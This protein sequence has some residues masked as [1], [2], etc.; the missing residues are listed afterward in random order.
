MERVSLSKV[1]DAILGM[2]VRHIHL[3][4]AAND[5]DRRLSTSNP[6]PGRDLSLFIYPIQHQDEA[7]L[8]FYLYIRTIFLHL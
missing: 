2:G 7:F 8:P 6:T 1:E 5:D 3:W 4:Q